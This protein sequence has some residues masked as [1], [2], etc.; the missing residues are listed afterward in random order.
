MTPPRLLAIAGAELWSTGNLLEFRHKLEHLGAV[1]RHTGT[2]TTVLL[3]RP[4]SPDLPLADLDRWQRTFA[5]AQLGWGLTAPACAPEAV[6]ADLAARG[7]IWV[8]LPEWA[9]DRLPM[10]LAARGAT[11]V[12]IA[13]SCHDAAGVDAALDGG[14]DFAL[15]SP[16]LPTPSKP[17]VV[18]LGL[19]ALRAL[20]LRWPGRVLAL[21]GIG[22]QE[23][24]AV[25]AAGAAGVACMRAPWLESVAELARACRPT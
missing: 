8:Q 16:I 18:P 2:P 20:A 17:G 4:R 23:A 6:V 5:A 25:L 7:V 10:W 22:A 19:E 9:A 13:R 3:R 15:L 11:R 24:G 1:I 12:A 21:G 14:A